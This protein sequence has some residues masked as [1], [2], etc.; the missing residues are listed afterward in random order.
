MKKKALEKKKTKTTKPKTKSAAGK[1]S[2]PLVSVI[3]G[4][5]S[6]W[7]TMKLASDTLNE[8]GVAHECKIVS[9]HRTPDLLATFAKSAEKRGIEVII[10]GAGGS[11]H[12]PGMTAAQTILPVLGVPMLTKYLAGFDSVLS[13]WQMPPGIP[14]GTLAIGDA[15]AKNAALLAVSILA[16]SR[17]KLKEKLKAFRKTQTAN[18]LKMVLEK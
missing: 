11:A 15:G 16:N 8:F 5:K 4:S 13:M 7:Q 2:K 17:P 1:T 3:M 12:L 14:V 10:A 9:A 18:V 6:D